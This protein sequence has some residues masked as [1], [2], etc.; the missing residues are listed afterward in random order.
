MLLLRKKEKKLYKKQ[1]FFRIC[2]KEFNKQVN[3]NQNYDKFFHDC[4][5]TEKYCGPRPIVPVI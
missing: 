2:R 4:H 5:Y 1:T 3:E